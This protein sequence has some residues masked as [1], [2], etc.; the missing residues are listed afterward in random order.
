[1]EEE[2]SNDANGMVLDANEMVLDVFADAAAPALTAA[3]IQ[4]HSHL[5]LD[6]LRFARFIILE[7]RSNTVL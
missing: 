4:T 7:T 2:S 5:L 3:A 6:G 1:M